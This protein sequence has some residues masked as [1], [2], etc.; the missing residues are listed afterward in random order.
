MST[1]DDQ[2]RALQDRL[3][4]AHATRHR[5]A[6]AHDAAQA[7]VT[8]LR[9]LLRRDYGFDDVQQARTWLAQADTDV[10]QAVDAIT[11]ALDDRSAQ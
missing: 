11:A 4:T 6:A 10:R 9:D 1:L 8:E 2:V 3:A 7:K 5:A